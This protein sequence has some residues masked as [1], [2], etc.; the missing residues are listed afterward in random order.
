[1]MWWALIFKV[2]SFAVLAWYLL[3]PLA[4]CVHDS[5]ATQHSSSE[6]CKN[7]AACGA[8]RVEWRRGVVDVALQ[9]M[10]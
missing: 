1:M 5:G 10:N 2:N 6:L 3:R 8:S 9:L 7:E 4:E